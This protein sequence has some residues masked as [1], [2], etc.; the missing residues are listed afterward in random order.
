MTKANNVIFA[1]LLLLVLCGCGRVIRG[2][3]IVCS[4]AQRDVVPNWAL[5]CIRN[6]NQMADDPEDTVQQCTKAAPRLLC[7]RVPGFQ[8]VGE[9]E[10]DMTIRP[11]QE[12][13]T[14]E[15]KSV[16]PGDPGGST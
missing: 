4:P 9:F 6:A 16:C 1:I 5:E 11:C 2:E 10:V 12:A 7:D 15:E 14:E 3:A 13:T 8:H